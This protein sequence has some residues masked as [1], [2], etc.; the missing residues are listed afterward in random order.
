MMSG[1]AVYKQLKAI[2]SDS[3]FPLESA[4]LAEQWKAAGAGLD[5]V[6]PVLRF[7]EE[8]PDVDYGVPGLLVS[9]V[10]TF[11]RRGYEPLLLA[12][13]RRKPTVHT[14]WMLNR[15]VNGAATEHERDA[16]IR[17]LESAG[18]NPAAGEDVR[19]EVAFFLSS[20]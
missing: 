19:E 14:I 12:S 1:E 17:E 6:E 2:A 11:Y 13:V 18:E 4:K 8:H 9:F 7:M 5:V 15:L 3:N 10:E 20:H 16:Y